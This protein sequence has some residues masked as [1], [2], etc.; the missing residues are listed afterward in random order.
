MA[1]NNLKRVDMPLN[2]ETKPNHLSI[3]RIVLLP[4]NAR[5]HLARISQD[6]RFDRVSSILAHPLYLP[7]FVARD[8]HLFIFLQIALN[9]KQ[10]SQENQVKTFVENFLN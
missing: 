2:K 1:L 3:E 6:K 4:D 10:F 5:P 7:D 8:S 9:G